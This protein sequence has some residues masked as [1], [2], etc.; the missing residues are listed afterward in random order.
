M[1]GTST[2][3]GLC[4]RH[5]LAA[6]LALVVGLLGFGLFASQSEAAAT[7]PTVTV[8]AP[9]TLTVSEQTTVQATL[10][11]SDM[12]TGTIVFSVYD[13]DDPACSREPLANLPPIPVDDDGTYPQLILP[14]EPGTFYLVAR[15]SGDVANPA[16]ANACGDPGS[17]LN[18]IDPDAVVCPEHVSRISVTTF[19]RPRPFSDAPQVMGIRTRLSAGDRVIA[20]VSPRLDYWTAGRSKSA[21]LNMREFLLDRTKN[22]RFR[23]PDELIRDFRRAGKNPRR[24]RVNLLLRIRLRAAGSSDECLQNAPARLIE[25]RLTTVSRRVSLR[26]FRP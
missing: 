5:R 10:T 7:A 23:A 4:P 9:E 24:A 12:A 22:V 21:F 1:M 26:A 13:S 3:S 20:E 17:V 15:Y 18:V 25:T 19:P 6:L 11:G 14:P 16:A 8:T 2:E